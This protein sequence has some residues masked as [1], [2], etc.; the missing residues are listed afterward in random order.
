MKS[1]MLA[2]CGHSHEDNSFA[3]VH[4][5]VAAAEIPA[6]TAEGARTGARGRVL[7]LCVH[8][9]SARRSMPQPGRRDDALQCACGN[10]RTHTAGSHSAAD[11][12]V[13]ACGRNALILSGT[14]MAQRPRSPGPGDP[15]ACG[16]WRP[17]R[18]PGWRSSAPVSSSAHT[19]GQGRPSLSAFPRLAA[20][21]HAR[22]H[23][24]TQ[25]PLRQRHGSGHDDCVRR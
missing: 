24:H 20:C 13:H 11:A 21:A 9:L 15:S 22:T 1:S 25:S 12:G 19:W 14:R 18:P 5:T 10:T 7:V 3:L 8:A 4:V 17:W 2:S 16:S 6:A 23:A